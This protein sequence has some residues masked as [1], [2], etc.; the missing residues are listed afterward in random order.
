MASRASANSPSRAWAVAFLARGVRFHLAPAIL[1]RC[2]DHVTHLLE[3]APRISIDHSRRH[4]ERGH[5]GQPFVAEPF[6]KLVALEQRRHPARWEAIGDVLVGDPVQDLR[7]A[8]NSSFCSRAIS[9]A[10]FSRFTTSWYGLSLS[11][12]GVHP[13]IT[14][15]SCSGEASETLLQRLVCVLIVSSSA[16]LIA[17]TFTACAPARIA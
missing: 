15:H 11:A 6:R 8:G 14:S 13:R 10:S 9:S 2:L 5:P 12:A 17:Y 7:E 16:S 4:P 1:A 3:S